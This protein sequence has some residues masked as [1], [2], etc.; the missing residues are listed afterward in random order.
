MA[1]RGCFNLSAVH[2]P[3]SVEEICNGAFTGCDT[4]SVDLKNVKYD[5]RGNCNAIIEQSSGI[6]I[7]GCKNTTIPL[8]VCNIGPGA[9]QG[10]VGLDHLLVP[11]SII[12]IGEGAFGDCS[13]LQ[14][15]ELPESLQRIEGFAF[16]NCKKLT[17]LNIPYGVVKIKDTVFWGCDNLKK[18]YI[19]DTVESIGLTTDVD[20]VASEE[21]KHR[22]GF[23]R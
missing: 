8:S 3:A 20:V 22:L 9:F 6:L 10:C 11:D 16:Q 23:V 19:P 18:V 5:S 15:V 12:V 2:I 13:N 7:C 1:F 4:I 14:K 17:E 21:V